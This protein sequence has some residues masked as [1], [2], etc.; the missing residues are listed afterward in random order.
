MA[1]EWLLP[2]AALFT[3][4]PKARGRATNS[5]AL[6][7]MP[8]APAMRGGIAAL[9]VTQQASDSVRREARVASETVDA[10]TLAASQDKPL[11]AADL[12]RFPGLEAVDKTALATRLNDTL[13]EARSVDATE[14]VT[15]AKALIAAKGAKIS[16]ADLAKYPSVERVLD[17]TDASGV[18]AAD[19]GGA[20]AAAV[21]GGPPAAPAERAG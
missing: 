11:A 4:D 20:P 21:D 18:V 19:G 10:M 5:I 12:D 14:L 16:A 17:A 9:A 7:M 2:F 1:N 13:G 6:T 3:A 15:F 8:V